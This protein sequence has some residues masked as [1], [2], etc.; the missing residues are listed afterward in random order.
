[1]I[2]PER[3]DAITHVVRKEV[4]RSPQGFPTV[5]SVP[6]PR[7]RTRRGGNSSPRRHLVYTSQSSDGEY[8]GGDSPFIHTP[9]TQE[10][11]S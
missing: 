10:D 8:S 1:M 9:G 5:A 3:V 6:S 7:A 11:S 2:G 4:V